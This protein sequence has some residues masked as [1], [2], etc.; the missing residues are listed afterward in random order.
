MENVTAVQLADCVAPG[1][2]EG[3]TYRQINAQT[4]HAIPLGALVEQ[5]NGARLF[6]VQHRRD[7][8][9]TPLY[10]LAAEPDETAQANILRGYLEYGLTVVR[11]PA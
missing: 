8:D 7:C 2:P 11:L 9:Q 5:E 10:D 3:R 6:V 1:D 4:A